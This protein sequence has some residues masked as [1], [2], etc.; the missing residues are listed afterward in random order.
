MTDHALVVSTR[1]VFVPGLD[2]LP[3]LFRDAG[4]AASLRLIE[5]FT[6]TIRNRNTREAYGRAVRD[7]CRWCEDRKITLRD[8]SPFLVAAYVEELG[9]TVDRPSVKQK[10]AALK[11]LFDWLVTGQVMPVNPAASVRGPR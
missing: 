1:Q 8:I 2:R 10:L 4:E 6:V 5:F 3:K 7:F 9:T 11:M